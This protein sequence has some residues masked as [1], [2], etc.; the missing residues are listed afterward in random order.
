MVL[1]PLKDGY[2]SGVEIMKALM[3]QICIR[4]TKE[5]Q[6]SEGNYLVPL[7]PVRELGCHRLFSLTG[8]SYSDPGRHYRCQSHSHRGSS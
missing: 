5:M 2:P 7:P 6:D 3:N 4:R 8:L 1:R